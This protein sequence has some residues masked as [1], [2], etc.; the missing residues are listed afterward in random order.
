MKQD[1]ILKAKC[2]LEFKQAIEQ[3]AQDAHMTIK[4]YIL[5]CLTH[6]GP[7]T[8]KVI[9]DA[10][11]RTYSKMGY[12]HSKINRMLRPI[13]AVHTQYPDL[14]ITLDAEAI[15][16]WIEVHEQLI[17]ILKQGQRETLFGIDP[18]EEPDPLMPDE[19]LQLNQS[20][21]NADC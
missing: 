7:P 1:S 11:L 5:H 6:K 16:T 8:P 3:R 4:D 14:P 13:R 10:A 12:L 17:Q 20:L 18:E 19:I 15:A 21:I 2:S 9:T